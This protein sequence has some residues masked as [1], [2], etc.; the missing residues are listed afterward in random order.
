MLATVGVVLTTALVG[1]AARLVLGFPWL[2]S[3]LLGA[4]VSSTDAAAVFFL[5]RVGGIHLRDRVRSVLEV[6]SGVNDPMAIFLTVTL[7]EL[8]DGGRRRSR[9]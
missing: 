8:I 3:F 6:E 1:V 4:V 2:Q 5:L 9:A 7:V